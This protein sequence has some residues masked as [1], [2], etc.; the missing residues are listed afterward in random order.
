MS[1]TNL[2]SIN[3]LMPGIAHKFDASKAIRGL[4]GMPRAVLLIGQAASVQAAKNAGKRL[5]VTT[6]SDALAAFGE[7]SMLMAMWR[8]AKQNIGLGMPLDAIVLADDATALAAKGSV[9]ITVDGSHASGELPLY[10]GGTRIRIGVAVN[11]TVATV[12][13]KLINAINADETLPIRASADADIESKIVL[14]CN[15]AGATG[16]FIDL[17][18]QFTSEDVIPQGVSIVVTAM[19]GGAVEPD[20]TPAIAAMQGYRAT[21]IAMPYSDSTNVGILEVELAKRWDYDNMQD[22]QAVIVKRGTEGELSSWLA[23]RNS[24]QMHTIC[25]TKD[26]TS[27]WETAAMV[28]A[29]IESHCDIDPAVPFTGLT[30]VGYKAAAQLDDFEAEQKNNLLLD[31][32]SAL[33]ITSDGTANLLRVVTN[34]TTHATGARDTSWRNLNWVKTLSYY[35][36]YTVYVF[37]TKYRGYKLVQYLVDPLPG[38][39]VMSKE[40]ATDVMLR[41]YEEFIDAG[42]FQNMD[43]Y[44]QVLLVEID[45][46]NG[47]VKIADEPVLVTQHYQTEI[48]SSFIAGTV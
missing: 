22:T 36:W 33:E 19:S 41:N 43:Y 24:H 20:I 37:Q 8:A 44:K 18:T 9:S 29:A 4:T 16:N 6:E 31:G 1:M 34:Y 7:G 26:R 32:G 21:E 46:T 5:R 2:F 12:R 42:L 27:P 3:W 13:T 35:R 14:T 39:K 17:R 48:T 38:Q 15:W 28:A 23:T 45:G 25:V 47:K 40:L 30:L 11:D 10:I